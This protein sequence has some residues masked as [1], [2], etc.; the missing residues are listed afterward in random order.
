MRKPLI[1][2]FFCSALL[3]VSCAHSPAVPAVTYWVA[4]IDHGCKPGV[5]YEIWIEGGVP[6]H[7]SVCILDPRS[8]EIGKPVRTAVRVVAPMSRIEQ[9]GSALGFWLPE[10]NLG[11]LPSSGRI[12]PREALSGAIGVR[13][14]ATVALAF[15]EK[16]AGPWFNL[17]K[18]DV[19]FQRIE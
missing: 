6:T 7:G 13:V 18:D 9:E 2:L 4:T 16:E 14:P 10:N 15:D 3:T 1:L 12:V 11:G 19:I 8:W 5:A 17:D